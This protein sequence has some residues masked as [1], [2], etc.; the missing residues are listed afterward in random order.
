MTQTTMKS[1]QS[2]GG[3]TLVELAIV[4]IIIGLLI[5][6]ILKGQ[7]LIQNAR[8]SSSVTQVK[9][10]EAA[11]N[12]FQDKYAALPGDI[13]NV[14]TRLPNCTGGCN[15]SGDG[16]S[17]IEW[18]A[19]NLGATMNTTPSATNEPQVFTHLGAANLLS[20]N[21]QPTAGLSV[22][23]SL[24]NLNLGGSLRLGYVSAAVTGM[25]S[26]TAPVNGHYI[27]IGSSAALDASILSSV[28]MANIDRKLDD[29]L[30]NVGSVYAVGAAGCA[31]GTANTATYSEA[32]VLKTCGAII[33]AIN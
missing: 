7:E 17:T 1:R 9:A 3:F 22:T 31:S 33:R 16:D 4:M 21:V 5:G 29:G 24:P 11:V 20:G 12:T 30:P 18:A 6:G 32:S 13:T 2:E 15:N 10:V 26:A 19:G 8:V 14:A 23:T 25:I 27:G 28:D